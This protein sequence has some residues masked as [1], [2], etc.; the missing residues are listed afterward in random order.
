MTTSTIIQSLISYLESMIPDVTITAA[1]QLDK[2]DLPCIAVA[3]ASSEPHSI[4]LPGVLNCEIE[5]TLRE[6]SGDDETGLQDTVEQLLNEV[7]IMTEVLNGGIRVDHWQYAGATES[8][9]EA[10]RETTYSANLLAVRV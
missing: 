2:V 6:H 9:D 10:V 4:A 3:I 7:G 5:I 8:W 1:T